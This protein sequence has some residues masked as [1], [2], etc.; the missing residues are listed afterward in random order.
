MFKKILGRNILCYILWCGWYKIFFLCIF[1]DK[2]QIIK[3]E[4]L[5]TDKSNPETLNRFNNK[6]E[7]FFI[8]R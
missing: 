8:N 2:F 3:C 4:I 6:K 1:H 7:C 5:V